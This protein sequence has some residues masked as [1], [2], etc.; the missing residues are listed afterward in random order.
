MSADTR[1]L[2]EIVLAKADG[3]GEIRDKKLGTSDD[4]A[5]LVLTEPTYKKIWG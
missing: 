1:K 5:P 3:V 4:S 2:F